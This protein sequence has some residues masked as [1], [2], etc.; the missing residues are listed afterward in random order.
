MAAI[1]GLHAELASLRPLAS[2]LQAVQCAEAERKQ[3]EQAMA[4]AKLTAARWRAAAG[5]GASADLRDGDGLGGVERGG[6]PRPSAYGKFT[7]REI[8]SRL[9]GCQKQLQK[10]G[11]RSASVCRL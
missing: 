10:Q 9:W 5:A 2:Q 1:E 7:V 8:A 11:H 6:L 3:A 4:A